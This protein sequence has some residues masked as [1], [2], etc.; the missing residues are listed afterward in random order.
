MAE[1]WIEARMPWRGSGTSPPSGWIHWLSSAESIAPIMHS[2]G[3]EVCI[4]S[5]TLKPQ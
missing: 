3:G 2:P 5:P 4:L 1:K